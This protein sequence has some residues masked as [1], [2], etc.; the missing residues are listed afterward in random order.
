MKNIT[1]ILLLLLSCRSSKDGNNKPSCIWYDTIPVYDT[2]YIIL[3]KTIPLF[4][5]IIRYDT[6]PLNIN[7]FLLVDSLKTALFIEKYKVERVKYYLR[8]VDNNSSQEKYL[9]GW[10]KRAIK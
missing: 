10:I 7:S 3:N 4:D 8:I 6:V 1:F 2:S 9:K 5:T